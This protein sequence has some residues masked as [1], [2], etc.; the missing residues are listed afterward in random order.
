MASAQ[1][2]VEDA[3]LDAAMGLDL[4]N[5]GYDL[6]RDMKAEATELITLDLIEFYEEKEPHRD[7]IEDHV[8]H[9]MSNYQQYEIADALQ[10]KFGCVPPCWHDMRS[11]RPKGRYRLSD[12]EARIRTTNV[13][14]VR[15]AHE[16]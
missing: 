11:Q 15:S 9:L 16:A 14:C 6:L 5:E 3:L 4:E 10:R 1:D 2:P 7:G 8:E 12:L 13:T